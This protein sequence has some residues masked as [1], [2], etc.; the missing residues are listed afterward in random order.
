MVCERRVT[1][2]F[3]P[4]ERPLSQRIA[5]VFFSAKSLRAQYAVH[6][7]SLNRSLRRLH[8]V[9]ACQRVVLLLLRNGEPSAGLRQSLRDWG[10]PSARGGEAWAHQLG[11]DCTHLGHRKAG[12]LCFRA[13]GEGHAA[14]LVVPALCC[15]CA[16]R[17]LSVWISGL[18]PSRGRPGVSSKGTH[19]ISCE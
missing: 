19:R 12:K 11:Q 2:I 6:S 3:G 9:P 4:D 1:S 10:A 8:P 13:F 5:R 16:A 15:L 17:V 18:K 7:A 14:L